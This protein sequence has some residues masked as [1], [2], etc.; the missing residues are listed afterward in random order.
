MT[1]GWC[2]SLQLCDFLTNYILS[3]QSTMVYLPRVGKPVQ[4]WTQQDLLTYN[5]HICSQPQSMFFNGLSCSGGTL[6]SLQSASPLYPLLTTPAET[7]NRTPLN[8]SLPSFLFGGTLSML[9]P[10]KF[11]SVQF[12][13]Y[14]PWTTNLDLKNWFYRFRPLNLEM[15]EGCSKG[16]LY[17]SP[18][19][20]LDH[21]CVYQW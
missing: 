18:A 5:I 8:W 11:G 14:F 20:L 6:Q 15:M 3:I 21:I 9:G 16:E 19:F 1:Y 10:P 13:D 17:A 7:P 12:S 4:D 2:H